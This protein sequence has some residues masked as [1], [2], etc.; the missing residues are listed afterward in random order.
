MHSIAV[1]ECEDESSQYMVLFVYDIKNWL[2]RSICAHQISRC[3]DA[4][5]S[6]YI[7]AI[8]SVRGPLEDVGQFGD[9][10]GM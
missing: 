9:K 6:T 10:Q 5:G 7:L 1:S 2:K 8:P 3:G 4:T